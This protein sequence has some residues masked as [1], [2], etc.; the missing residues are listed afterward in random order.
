MIVVEETRHDGGKRFIHKVLCIYVVAPVGHNPV[1][2]QTGW[3]AR[4]GSKDYRVGNKA[5]CTT[6]VS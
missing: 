1:L 5:L 3:C 6:P 4:Q 2:L